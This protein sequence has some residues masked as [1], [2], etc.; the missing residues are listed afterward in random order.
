MRESMDP[1]E[2]DVKTMIDEVL[3]EIHKK[4]PHINN[5]REP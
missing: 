3:N 1:S 5:K 4:K 2:E